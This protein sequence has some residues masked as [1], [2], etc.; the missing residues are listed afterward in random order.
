ML[1]VHQ[2]EIASVRSSQAIS[3]AISRT[4]FEKKKKKKKKTVNEK[5]KTNNTQQKDHPTQQHFSQL[6]QAE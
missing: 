4:F 3:N 1:P 5:K 2:I 6:I